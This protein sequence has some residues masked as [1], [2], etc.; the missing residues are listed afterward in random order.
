MKQERRSESSDGGKERKRIVKA[1]L[2]CCKFSGCEQHG[3]GPHKHHNKDCKHHSFCEMDKGEELKDAENSL[4]FPWSKF[5]DRVQK[6]TH[7]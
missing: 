5:E 3:F 1:D 2:T 7:Q 6:L 4:S